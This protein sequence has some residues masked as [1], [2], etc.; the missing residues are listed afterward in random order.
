MTVEETIDKLIQLKLPHRVD[1]HD[2]LGH[3]A[4]LTLLV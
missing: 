2:G 3:A 4:S 1:I